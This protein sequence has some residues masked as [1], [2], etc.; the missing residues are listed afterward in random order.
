MAFEK[1]QSGNPYG[2]KKGTLNKSTKELRAIVRE[3]LNS[4][5][6]K[7]KIARDLKELTPKYRLDFYFKLLEYTLPKPTEMDN[8]E[9]DSKTD[10]IAR[11]IADLNTKR[12][13]DGTKQC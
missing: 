7:A 11:V 10:F 3:V 2:R 9:D 5:F 13:P 1:G 4:N 6:T 12:N 8:V